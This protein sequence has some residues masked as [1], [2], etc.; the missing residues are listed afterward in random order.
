MTGGAH[1][2]E[3][4]LDTGRAPGDFHFPPRTSAHLYKVQYLATRES[5]A[6][7]V[8]ERADGLSGVLRGLLRAALGRG[9]YCVTVTRQRMVLRLGVEHSGH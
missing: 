6:E 4:S 3:P 1:T 7:T 5:P 9:A 8:T 2:S